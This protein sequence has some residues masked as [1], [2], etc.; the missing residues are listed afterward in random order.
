MKF[1]PFIV[2]LSITTLSITSAFAQTTKETFAV[3][4]NCGMCKN[5]IEAA[6]KTA[7]AAYASWDED[8]K[9]LTLQQKDGKAGSTKIL[10][11]V[12]AA[13]YDTPAM[14]AST[15]AYNKLHACCKYERVPETADAPATT[16]CV[17]QAGDHTACANCTGQMECCKGA[18]CEHSSAKSAEA[19]K[20][21]KDFC[22]KS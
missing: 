10:A 14:K 22:K 3:P 18:K 11:A 7:G 16:S 9:M 1:F 13:G 6:A 8:A 17:H 19:A 21:Q 5:K 4:G 15:E 2:L 12:A 20:G